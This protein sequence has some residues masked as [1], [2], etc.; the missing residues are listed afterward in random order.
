MVCLCLGCCLLTTACSDKEPTSLL[1]GEVAGVSFDCPEGWS[2]SADDESG[3]VT[4]L[5]DNAVAIFGPTMFIEVTRDERQ[6]SVQ[7]TLDHL[8]ESAADERKFKLLRNELITHARGFKYGLLEYSYIDGSV[9][10]TERFVIVSLP[11]DRLLI[12][13]M[14]GLRGRW[15]DYERNFD[16]VIESLE[17]PPATR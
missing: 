12:V 7:T 3:S 5:R 10:V 14:K 17:L 16:A 6:R 11:A 9:G 1:R 2:L 8:A 4:L 15:S 13:A